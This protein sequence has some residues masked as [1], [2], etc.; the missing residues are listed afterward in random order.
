MGSATPSSPPS[1]KAERAFSS[2]AASRCVRSSTRAVPLELGG[3]SSNRPGESSRD[4]TEFSNSPISLAKACG[5]DG[6][7]PRLDVS[8]D[9]AMTGTW[10]V[11]LD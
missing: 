9:E 8:P 2:E 4:P 1:T 3:S 5:A 6:N 10:L 11:L 7:R